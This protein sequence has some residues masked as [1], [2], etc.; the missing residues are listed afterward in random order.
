[1]DVQ[2]QA[3]SQH[4][5][6]EEV[7]FCPLHCWW[8]TLRASRVARPLQASSS[9]FRMARHSRMIPIQHFELMPHGRPWYLPIDPF[10]PFSFVFLF[11]EGGWG[12]TTHPSGTLRA[13][14]SPSP[15]LEN[16]SGTGWGRSYRWHS[17]RS[18]GL[19]K[20]DDGAFVGSGAQKLLANAWISVLI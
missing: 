1:M 18:K 13:I 19:L 9:A 20:A 14:S 10:Q 11:M 16:G 15:G 5:H 3:T 4:K 6:S 17:P 8:L 2:V 7:S 12:C